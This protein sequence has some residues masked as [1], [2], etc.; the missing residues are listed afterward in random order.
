M[1]DAVKQEQITVHSYTTYGTALQ[2]E[3][4]LT[5][6]KRVAVALLVHN[7]KQPGLYLRLPTTVQFL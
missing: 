7:F 4:S 3:L 1:A 5:F 6:A 2:P